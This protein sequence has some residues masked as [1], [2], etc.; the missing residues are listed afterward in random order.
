M[1]RM[2]FLLLT[3]T[4]CEKPVPCS[5][6]SPIPAL[7]GAFFPMPSFLYL[8]SSLCLCTRTNVLQSKVRENNEGSRLLHSGLKS[9]VSDGGQKL[10]GEVS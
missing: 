3:G 2:S 8:P 1:I 10:G 5:W 4:L 9:P 7:L 6:Y